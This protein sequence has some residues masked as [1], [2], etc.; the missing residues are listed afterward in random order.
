MTSPIDR[1]TR[2]RPFCGSSNQAAA[3]HSA[4]ALMPVGAPRALVVRV[5]GIAIRGPFTSRGKIQA[6]AER[7]AQTVHAVGDVRPFPCGHPAIT[8]SRRAIIAPPRSWCSASNANSAPILSGVLLHPVDIYGAPST[9]PSLVRDTRSATTA[10]IR[11]VTRT[12]LFCVVTASHGPVPGGA[13]VDVVGSC[14]K[15]WRR[16]SWRDRLV[17]RGRSLI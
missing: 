12:S 16:R 1:S 9:T 11:S 5:V 14:R 8:G 7:I 13:R 17:L 10:A 4:L 2:S 6:V 15:A 3:G